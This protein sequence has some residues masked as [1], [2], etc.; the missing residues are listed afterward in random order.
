[1][2]QVVGH[3]REGIQ[4][5]QRLQAPA[6]AGKR[7]QVYDFF[8]AIPARAIDQL[9]GAADLRDVDR[10]IGEDQRLPQFLVFQLQKQPPMIS[11]AR[12]KSVSPHTTCCLPSRKCT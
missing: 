7:Q 6:P 9:Q 4:T 12:K 1:M 5:T 3:Q 11:M 10:D 2:L 8:A